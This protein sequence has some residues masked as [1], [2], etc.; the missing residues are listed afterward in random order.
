MARAFLHVPPLLLIAGCVSM[1]VT[2]AP[3]VDAP[4]ASQTGKARTT[5]QT[6]LDARLRGAL[7][8]AGITRSSG[9]TQRRTAPVDIDRDGKALVDI[10]AV[11]TPEL[12]AGI[13]DLDGV[14]VAKFP[15][16]RSIRAR[17][18]LL[19]VETLAGRSD[20]KFVRAAEQAITNPTDPEAR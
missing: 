19:K 9:D 7:E 1:P 11:V 4:P 8:R 5:A 14:V 12:I 10:E 15:A 13:S 17:V 18:P 3:G 2:A 20:V 16:Y 6:K